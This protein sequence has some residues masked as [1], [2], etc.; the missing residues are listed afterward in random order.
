MQSFSG[1]T[2]NR[3]G[4]V[5]NGAY[6]SHTETSGVSLLFFSFPW[7]RCQLDALSQCKIERD[8]QLFLQ[9]IPDTLERSYERHLRGVKTE[10]TD[11]VRETLIWLCYSQRP[12]S[13]QELSQ[14]IKASKG[15]LIVDSVLRS[16]DSLLNVCGSL[17]S[18]DA[19]TT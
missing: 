14:G 16:P 8:I 10:H 2:S 18:Y 13:F 5:A 15:G 19:S 7:V 1:F 9:D 6:S 17:I 12:M 3:N 4:C 11:I